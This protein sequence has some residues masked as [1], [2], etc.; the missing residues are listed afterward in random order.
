MGNGTKAGGILAAVLWIAATSTTARASLV[1]YYTD[2]NA[3]DTNPAAP[4]ITAG[5]TPVQITNISTFNFSTVTMI[6]LYEQSHLTFS[7]GLV[8]RFADLASWVASG[9]V[10]FIHDHRSADNSIIPGGS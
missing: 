6:N 8:G 9:G 7:A 3:L 10:L 4:I 2:F 5:Q 1:A